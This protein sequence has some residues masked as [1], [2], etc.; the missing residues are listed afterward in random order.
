[1]D[2]PYEVAL[3]FAGEERAYVEEVAVGLRSHGVR[4]FYDSFQ[5]ADLWGR[6]LGELL[7]HIYSNAAYTVMFVSEAYV[8]KEWTRHERRS[9]LERVI[10]KQVDSVLPARFDDVETPGLPRTVGHIDLRRTP[11]SQLV[12]LLL[13]KLGRDTDSVPEEHASPR[14]AL[15]TLGEMTG[16]RESF[17]RVAC[18]ERLTVGWLDELLSTPL[19]HLLPAL[20]DFARTAGNEWQYKFAGLLAARLGAP[21]FDLALEI[22]SDEQVGWGQRTIVLAWLRHASGSERNR[23]QAAVRTI[24]DTIEMDA[25][26]LQVIAYGYLGDRLALTHLSRR[27]EVTSDSYA[28]EKL[29]SYFAKAY[30]DA[31]VHHGEETLGGYDLDDLPGT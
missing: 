8:R 2:E 24:R 29:G 18:A 3:S 10:T 31:Y 13:C 26:R 28:S 1:M 7:S 30:I 27:E 17:V 21:A 16:D 23:L 15:K 5:Q 12:D 9:A 6:D 22:A 20:R 25:L 11:P 14:S 4:V 19:D